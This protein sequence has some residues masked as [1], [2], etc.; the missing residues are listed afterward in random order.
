MFFY[1]I[2]TT[3]SKKHTVNRNREGQDCTMTHHVNKIET[4]EQENED[5][6]RRT[7]DRCTNVWQCLIDGGSC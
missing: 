1:E 3:Y 2:D 5:C 4:L 7:D 6:V